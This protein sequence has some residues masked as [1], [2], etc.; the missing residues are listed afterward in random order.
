[1]LLERNVPVEKI[2]SL[3]KG[4]YFIDGEIIR[5][6]KYHNIVAFITSAGSRYNAHKKPKSY[7]LFKIAPPLKKRDEEQKALAVPFPLRGFFFFFPPPPPPRAL[8]Q[9]VLNLPV[10]GPELLRRPA[11]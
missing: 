5:L 11:V 7:N 10:Q 6:W 1:V 4:A 2:R 8:R 9:Q 3:K